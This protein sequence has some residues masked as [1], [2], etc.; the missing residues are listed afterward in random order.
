MG[1]HKAHGESPNKGNPGQWA[2]TK[3]IARCLYGEIQ[4]IS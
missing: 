3:I 4:A 2:I 1:G